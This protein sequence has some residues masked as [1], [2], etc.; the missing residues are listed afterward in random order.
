MYLESIDIKDIET[1]LGS[2]DPTSREMLAAIL[3]LSI[4]N[5][6]TLEAILNLQI[7]ILSSRGGRD[8][9]SEK[10]VQGIHKRVIAIQANIV[11]GFG[12]D[13]ASEDDS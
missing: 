1:N 9:L 6:A 4:T 13:D 8:E 7:D 12:S 10:V 5:S 3:N 2:F 11:S